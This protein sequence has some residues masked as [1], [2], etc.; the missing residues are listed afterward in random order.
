MIKIIYQ[1]DENS[2]TVAK[3]KPKGQAEE[4]VIT[5]NLAGV[6]PGEILNVKGKWITHKKFG[7]QFKVESFTCLVPSSVKGIERYLSSG[8]IKGIG[9]VMAKRLVRLFGE[10]TLEVI[11]SMPERLAEVEGIGPKRTDMIMQAWDTQREIK[12]IML[13]LQSH[14]VSAALAVTIY[15]NYGQE[16]INIVK[17]N[18]YRLA[19]DIFGIGFKTA[20]KIAMKMSIPSD[21]VIRAKAGIL[22]ILDQMADK[23]HCFLPLPVLVEE[24]KGAL[25]IRE[26]LVIDAVQELEEEEKIKCDD[27]LF[28]DPRIGIVK[29]IYLSVFYIAETGICQLLKRLKNETRQIRQ[30]DTNRA[31]KWAET[32]L[33]MTLDPVQKEAVARALEGKITVITGGPGTGKTTIIKAILKIFSQLKIKIILAAPTGR[34]AKRMQEA[35]GYEAKT[36]HR[37]LEFNP[38][39]GKFIRDGQN[40]IRADLIVLDEVSMVDTILMYHLLKAIQPHSCVIIVGDSNQ[41]PSVGAGNV[42]GDI[43]NSGAFMVV[44]LQKIF[45]QAQRSLIVLNAHKILEGEFPIVP[46]KG[47][48]ADFFF[49]NEEEPEKVL[50]KIIELYKVHIPN[51]FKYDPYKDIQVI[52]PMN[53]GIVGTLNLNLELQKHLNP[54][55]PGITRGGKIIKLYDKVMQIRNSYDKE[56]FNGDIGRVIQ[57]DEDTLELFVEFD[58]RIVHYD[59]SDLDELVLAYSI[60][61]HKSQGSEYPVILMPITIQHFPLLQRNLIYTA[62]TRAK[63]LIVI[64]GTKKALSIAIRNNKIDRRYT[65]L[66]ERLKGV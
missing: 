47:D 9:P 6:Q 27:T 23:G 17:E 26:K 20:D 57:L 40:P 11:E 65:L 44:R 48:N 13:F 46:K 14:D 42:L 49:I 50:R 53:R 61:V 25:E 43:C 55:S 24:C 34:A 66:E 22:Y 4:I 39:K 3:F 21:S 41:L 36:I 35:T 15:K 29:C 7:L 59:I 16:A 5:G 18:P 19:T 8:L 31:V 30:V 62:L 54:I 56:V 45:R 37:L 2:F 58:N 52:T 51:R 10:E 64:I 60:S 63:K 1:D 28:I 12:Q 33:G 32:Q 38:Q